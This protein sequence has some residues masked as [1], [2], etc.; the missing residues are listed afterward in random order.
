[1]ANP[2]K[3]LLFLLGLGA[4]WLMILT[5]RE[6]S[7]RTK[8]WLHLMRNPLIEITAEHARVTGNYTDHFVARTIF[9][10]FAETRVARDHALDEMRETQEL[11]DHRRVLDHNRSIPGVRVDMYGRVV[12]EVTRDNC[13]HYWEQVTPG[14]LVCQICKSVNTSEGTPYVKANYKQLSLVPQPKPKPKPKTVA[15]LRKSKTRSIIL[16]KE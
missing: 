1:M 12:A 16:E 11:F 13:A 8:K 2:L 6:L 5:V 3:W 9:D 15:E 10:Q 7:V 14:V 4:G